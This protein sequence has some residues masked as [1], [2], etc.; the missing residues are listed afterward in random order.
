MPCA[1]T[2]TFPLQLD[3][4]LNRHYYTPMQTQK[5]R[6][7]LLLAPLLFFLHDL[8]EM[9]RMPAFLGANAERLPVLYA[10]L[11]GAQFNLTIAILTILT[12]AVAIPAA[13]LL[14]P[15]TVMTLYAFIAGARLA[16]VFVHL[17]Q[18]VYFRSLTP[19]AYTALPVLLPTAIIL[20]R[21]LRK[22]NF[23]TARQLCA[24][25]IAGLPLHSLIAPLLLFTGW[26]TSL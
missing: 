23:I 9:L 7:I 3:S 18:A 21:T 6:L 14:A 13:R 24:A 16:N 20:L 12:L 4:P 17:L 19:G 22:E 5:T 2:K 15:C 8:E 1:P 10:N 26:I 11:T 25:L